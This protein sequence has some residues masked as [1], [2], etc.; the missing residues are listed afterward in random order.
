M[1]HYFIFD[2]H[3]EQK[4]RVWLTE[5]TLEGEL[6]CDRDLAIQDAQVPQRS[7]RGKNDHPKLR[8]GEIPTTGMVRSP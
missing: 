7:R 6:R 3:Y 2:L 5:K 8:A 4:M 1:N